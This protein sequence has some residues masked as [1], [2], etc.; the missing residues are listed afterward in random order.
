[1]FYILVD[2]IIGEWT[3]YACPGRKIPAIAPAI[4]VASFATS[5]VPFLVGRFSISNSK[6]TQASRRQSY[7]WVI[8]CHERRAGQRR[9]PDRTAF[10]APD[11]PTTRAPFWFSRAE[12]KTYEWRGWPQMRAGF[13]AFSC[14]RFSDGKLDAGLRARSPRR[15]CAAWIW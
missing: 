8:L 10:G 14:C 4:P 2:C 15:H 6:E 12:L 13:V 3:K 7:I 5:V 11:T 1:M 9:L